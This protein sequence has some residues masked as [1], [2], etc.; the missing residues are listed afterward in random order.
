MIDQKE[1][2]KQQLDQIIVDNVEI[3]IINKIDNQYKKEV[4]YK[5]AYNRGS[6][7]IGFIVS[8]ISLLV[9]GS[10]YLSSLLVK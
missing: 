6:I 4:D 9:L 5:P 7:N 1:I 3:E 10:I 2:A 8:I